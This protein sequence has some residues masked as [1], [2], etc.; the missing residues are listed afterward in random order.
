VLGYVRGLVEADDE[1]HNAAEALTSGSE[2]ASFSSGR[3]EK[4]SSLGGAGT[5]L[6]PRGL[7]R[8]PVVSA[9]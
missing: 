7:S 2:R 1:A 4:L 6:K 9:S 3:Y 5:T 8:K